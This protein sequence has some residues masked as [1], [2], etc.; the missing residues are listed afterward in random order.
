MRSGGL[1]IAQGAPALCGDF[2]QFEFA[3]WARGH[4]GN[5]GSRFN[6]RFGRDDGARRDP[7]VLPDSR[8]IE[9][10]CADPDERAVRYLAAM[11]DRAMTDRDFVAED[12]RKPT[13]RHMERRLILD[14]SPLANA[15]SLD[16]TTEHTSI[17]DARVG[18]DLDIADHSRT[19]RDPHSFM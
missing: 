3:D 18:P 10:D 1:D 5:Q 7:C 17:E 6:R 14:I 19:R 11:H 15:D 12:R 16:I 8:A 13:G 9:N 4:A 2:V